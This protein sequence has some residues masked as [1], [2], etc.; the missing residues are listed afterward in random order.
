MTPEELAGRTHGI[1]KV[2]LL[3]DALLGGGGGAG[4]WRWCGARSGS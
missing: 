2:D 1:A 3:T 4:R